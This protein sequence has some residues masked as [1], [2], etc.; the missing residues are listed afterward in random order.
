MH[1]YLNICLLLWSLVI[2]E[3]KILICMQILLY[4]HFYWHHFFENPLFYRN[5]DSLASSIQRDDTANV[6]LMDL[7]NVN[8]NNVN[9]NKIFVKKIYWVIVMRIITS[10]VLC[11][12]CVRNKQRLSRKV[13]A[14]R[15]QTCIAGLMSV[16][17]DQRLA[18]CKVLQS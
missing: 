1:V 3:K 6:P 2:E 13:T 10:Y 11:N 16:C 8:F 5:F 7:I 17:W 9:I 18:S 15:P 14:V 12:S 4:I